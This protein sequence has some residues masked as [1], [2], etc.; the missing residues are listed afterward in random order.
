[1]SFDSSLWVPMTMSIWPA[2][3]PSSAWRL[4]SESGSATVRR[5]APVCRQSGRKRSGNAVRR[6]GGRAQHRHLAAAGRCDKGGAQGDLGLA[7]ADIAADQA[8]HRLAGGHV[9]DHGFDGGHLVRRFLEAEAIGEGFHIVLAGFER[10]ALAGGALGIQVEQFGRR[11]ARLF[12]GPAFGF[13]PL[14][15]AKTMQRRGVGVAA[16][17]TRD[18]VQMRDR[19]IQLVAAGEFQRQE[20]LRTVAHIHAGQALITADAVLDMHHRIADLQFG[21]IFQQAFGGAG[22]ACPR[23]RGG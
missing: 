17:I 1:M 12:H 10:M 23:G 8:V 4:P 13:F 6:A 9:A 20:F 18:Q 2:L 14:A 7:E 21:Q 11:V 16:E 19:H 15:A 5:A 22:C 3:M